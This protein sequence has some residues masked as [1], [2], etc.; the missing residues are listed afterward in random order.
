MAL[1]GKSWIFEVNDLYSS[2]SGLAAT[3][4]EAAMAAYVATPVSI[5]N[6]TIGFLRST[7]LADGRLVVVLLYANS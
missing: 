7:Q 6:T 3:A 2:T 1:V 4:I 5:V